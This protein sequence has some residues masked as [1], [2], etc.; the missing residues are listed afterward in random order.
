MLRLPSGYGRSLMILLVSAVLLS[1]CSTRSISNTDP[2][3]R[4]DFYA[5][6]LK[7]S[8]VM[9]A[10][11]PSKTISDD[12]IKNALNNAQQAFTL[13]ANA[14]ILLVQ[15]GAMTPDVE[16]Q[17]ALRKYYSIALYSGIP[18]D[19]YRYGRLDTDTKQTV[20]YPRQLRLTAAN[21]GQNKIMV[22]W[23]QLES[24]S[25]NEVTKVVSWVPLVGG[26]LPDETQHMRIVLR[27]ALIDV[28]SG[29]WTTFTPKV[30]DSEKVSGR[31][32]RAAQDARQIQALK[33]EAYKAAADEIY[34][35][36]THKS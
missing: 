28:V 35:R 7:D 9:G 14:N 2:R 10:V 29:R 21:G 3:G 17:D 34:Q 8:D 12:D 5:G 22:Y 36:F 30:F 25:E 18:P 4:N 15:S 27:I 1:G 31:Y 26:I 11:P 33:A 13:P 20:D 16:M 6:E 24:G 32:N 19:T 23:G